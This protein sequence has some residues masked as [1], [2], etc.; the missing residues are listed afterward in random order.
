M[1][2]V[3]TAI[4]AGLEK[5]TT[6][7]PCGATSIEASMAWNWSDRSAHPA[8]DAPPQPQWRSG[9]IGTGSLPS[10]IGTSGQTDGGHS[11]AMFPRSLARRIWKTNRPASRRC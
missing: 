2:G 1:L 9:I 7:D 6:D 10:A 5:P 11:K 4:E 8:L 3:S